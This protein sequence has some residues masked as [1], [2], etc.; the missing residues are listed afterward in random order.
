MSDPDA[1]PSV[2][3]AGRYR[4][5]D[6]LGRGGMSTVYGAW[7]EKLGRPVA[8]KVFSADGAIASDRKRRLREARVLASASHPHLVTLFDAEWPDDAEGR[9][10][11][12]LVMQLIEGESLRRRIDRLGPDR[13]LAVRVAAELGQALDYLHARGIVHRDIKPENILIEDA[14]GSIMLVDFGIAQLSGNEQLTT[15]GMVLGTA[16]YLSPEQVSGGQVGPATDVYSLGLVVLECLTGR[17][18]FPGST[19][20][21][22]VARL[23]RDPVLPSGLSVGWN[24]L[25]GSMMARD[26]GERPSAAQVAASVESLRRSGDL[27]AI[28]EQSTVIMPT[29]PLPSAQDAPTMRMSSADEVEQ[30][31]PTAKHPHRRRLA[32]VLAV[33]LAAAVVI[34]GAVVWTSLDAQQRQAQPV[35]L[36]TVIVTVSPTLSPTE[37]TVPAPTKVGHGH[38]KQ[39]KNKKNGN[40]QGD[41]G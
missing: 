33:A 2:L 23:A 35:P 31:A 26:A 8:V 12:F 24:D 3:L 27:P 41:D 36:P 15:A 13:D 18:E 10:P 17:R 19:V 25:L 1:A 39:K 20:E 7:D 30:S 14:G 21:S 4:L 6:A 22:S 38:E 34:A 32:V 29:L 37:T 16:A 40:D 5:A 9:H 11:A 28:D